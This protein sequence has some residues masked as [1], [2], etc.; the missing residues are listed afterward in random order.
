MTRL[1]SMNSK[2]KLSLAI[3][4]A[5]A[6]HAGIAAELPD[7]QSKPDAANVFQG[8][9]TL[10]ILSGE[11]NNVMK[12]N[13]FSVS[14]D[15]KVFFDDKN[16]LN[17]VTGGK[18][19]TINGEIFAVGNLYIVNPAGITAGVNS[20]I[21][22]S[23]LGLSTA[24]IG[25][26]AIESFNS[27]GVLPN[28]TVDGIGRA[29]LLGTIKANN[30]SVEGGQIVIR[31][32]TKITD[33]AGDK[34]TNRNSQALTLQSSMHRIDIG[35][36]TSTDIEEDYGLAD[37]EY[38]SHLGQT[39]I[40]TAAELQGIGSEGDYFITND[41][42]LG[43]ITSPL[44]GGNEFKGNIDGT[45]SKVSFALE[46][47]RTAQETNS[48][49]FAT[50]SNASF[51]NLRVEGSVSS[52]GGAGSSAGVIA[53][54]VRGGAFES[55]EVRNSS[56]SF[57]RE[58]ANRTAGGIAGTMSESVLLK[59]TSVVVDGSLKDI[60][61]SGMADVGTVAGRNSGSLKA[62]GLAF[63]A[64]SDGSV[65]DAV[66]MNTGTSALPASMDEAYAALADGDKAQYADE[67]GIWTDVRFHDVFTVTNF[68]LDEDTGTPDYGGMIK[69]EA[70]EPSAWFTISLEST[71]AETGGYAFSLSP[72]RSGARSLVF[73][74]TTKNGTESLSSAGLALVS[75]PQAKPEP[76]DPATPE[77]P[78]DSGSTGDAGGID[79][80][81]GDAGTTDPSD[82][83]EPSDPSGS[84]STNEG[85]DGGQDSGDA[86]STEPSEPSDPSGSTDDGKEDNQGSGDTENTNPSTPST[87]D[88]EPSDSGG[89]DAGNGKDDSAG[90]STGK[91][92]SGG[93]TTEQ[94]KPEDPKTDEPAAEEPKTEEPASEDPKEETPSNPSGGSSSSGSNSGS[95]AAGGSSSAQSSGSSS[96]SAASG[97]GT[98][99]REDSVAHDDGHD[100]D[101]DYIEISD[102]AFEECSEGSWCQ[103][104]TAEVKFSEYSKKREKMHTMRLR[105]PSLPGDLLASARATTQR[106]IAGLFGPGV[107]TDPVS[108]K[109]K[110]AV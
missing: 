81:S 62:S 72:K 43:T 66:G 53:G 8:E 16:Y 1:K 30:I 85:S 99:S 46:D 18:Q 42:D 5:L 14:D 39:P 48:G 37:G 69:S 75:V 60:A 21:N 4:A 105:V 44:G 83:S 34:L 71:P 63:S 67:G 31:D 38:V 92:S 13:T 24:P 82:P 58:A 89:S 51:R 47:P 11:K 15:A 96:G 7:L 22:A 93:T 110:A 12:W 79:Q 64:L 27:K 90:T 28:S 25:E 41:I 101:G 108:G 9:K 86:G 65:L 94:P 52:A 6:S 3:A 23:K 35:G 10:T 20:T 59:N 107:S 109:Q 97:S 61:A 74:N 98:A 19:S 49:L 84:D 100:E 87:S 102:L 91:G 17:L 2:I 68:T 57:T 80:G 103:V 40:S 78:S 45:F 104:L 54:S 76:S 36:P 33:L 106:A 32:I 26:D 50:A 55:V 29:N 56:V 70:F 95:N 73:S 77:D 88:P